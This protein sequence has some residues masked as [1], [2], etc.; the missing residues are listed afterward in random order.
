[1]IWAREAFP[2]L[3]PKPR[4]VPWIWVAPALTAVMLF[5]AMLCGCQSVG[6]YQD[7]AVQTARSFLLEE[8]P[9]I[10]LME[11]EFIKFNRPFI[12]AEPLGQNYHSSLMQI[13]ICWMTPDN[14]EAYMVYGVS[15]VRMIDWEPLRIV[16]RQF[17]RPDQSY[18]QAAAKASDELVQRQFPLLSA[19]SANHIRFTLP[20]VWKCKFPINLNPDIDLTEKEIDAAEKLPRYVLAWKI[21]ENGKTLYAIYGGTARNDRLEGFKGYFHG[22]YPFEEFAANL[23]ERKALIEPFGGAE[24]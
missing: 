17:K 4:R 20:G 8:S 22:L 11:Q 3:S 6:Y 18:L 12:L 19:A 23:T 7:Q 1:M 16:R 9:Q 21:R 14:P 13:C 24:K 15:S 5:A 10:P 2:H